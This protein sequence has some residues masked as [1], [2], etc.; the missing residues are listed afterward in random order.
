[1]CSDDSSLA[2]SL[3]RDRMDMVHGNSVL[4]AG[5]I[6]DMYIQTKGVLTTGAC[7]FIHHLQVSFTY[8]LTSRSM[9]R[10]RRGLTAWSTFSCHTLRAIYKHTHKHTC[11][12]RESLPLRQP[13]PL[14]MTCL[15][16]CQA[17]LY[18]MSLR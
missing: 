16:Q 5:M 3:M 2:W 8:L 11:T 18:R 14:T 1:M 13:T 15:K 17:R 12:Q 7:E 10:T 9:A 6:Q 4:Q